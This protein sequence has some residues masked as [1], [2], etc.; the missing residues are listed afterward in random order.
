MTGPGI[1]LAASIALMGAA[2]PAPIAP[3]VEATIVPVSSLSV[4]HTPAGAEYEQSAAV[5][6]EAEGAAVANDQEEADSAS[7]T[8]SRVFVAE[9]GSSVV[10]D[11]WSGDPVET[12]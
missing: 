10:A 1:F 7:L 12:D 2:F 8:F 5:R 11:D 4:L 6:V 3:T 9:D